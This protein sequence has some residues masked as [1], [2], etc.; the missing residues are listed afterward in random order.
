MNKLQR[1]HAGGRE[2]AV[3]LPPSYSAQERRYPVAYVQDGGQLIAPCVNY[4]EHLMIQGMLPEVI[5]VGIEPRNRLEEYTPWP[6][7]PLGSG[8][9]AFA[10]HGRAYVDDIADTLKPLIDERYR[11][12]PE[13]EH[14][15]M[16][17]GSLGGLISL[18]A[19]YWRAGTFGRIGLL[20]ASFWFEGAMDYIRERE[21]PD[22]R[23]RIF[24][25]VGS[26]EGMYKRNAQKNMARYAQEA[27]TI[28][29]GKGFPA[30]RLQFVLEEGGTH[31]MLFMAKQLPAA[32]RWLF[33][34]S[35]EAAGCR[36][37]HS[38]AFAE[39][40]YR[41]PGTRQLTMRARRTGREYRIFVSVPAAA[42]PE[43]GYPVLYALDGNATFASLAE[44]V[45]LQSR[46][47]RG[48]CPPTVIV[49]IGYDSE[50]PFVSSRRFFDY[51]EPAEEDKL[52]PRPDGSPWPETGGVEPFLLFI[53]EEVKPAIERL[54]LIDRQ[55]Q[56][57]FGH[58]LG[59]LF[60]LYVLFVRPAAFRCY[61]AGS[62]SV[63][64]NDFS[65]LNR[66]PL[67]RDKLERGEAEAAV[68]IGY[69]AEEKPSITQGAERMR[70]LLEPYQGRGLRLECRAFE[71]EGHV[72]VIP[73]LISCMLRFI[74][75]E[76]SPPSD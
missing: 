16:I 55:R 58:S 31:D 3:F 28:W 57:L 73:P 19:G 76:T 20:S 38:G 30:A 41:L 7:E 26:C 24:M 74:A 63:W 64:W 71:E 67:L 32:L 48:G 4:L 9:P 34:P 13:A 18:F 40:S 8:K 35:G 53:E 12:M 10:G 42:P 11:T 39:E 46:R 66:W 33:A 69:G 47:P 36:A 45:R 23:L 52:P 2:L 15:A 49:G 6:A 50:E 29:L 68:L 56:S 37:A 60:A 65:L 25:S 54:C 44:A 59:G 70:Q 43:N 14:T 62:P 27:C 5:L 17:G 1:I 72:S 22:S 51:T 21:A 75:R 61:I